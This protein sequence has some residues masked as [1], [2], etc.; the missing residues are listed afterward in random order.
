MSIK[1]THLSKYH[2][3]IYIKMNEKFPI[4][5]ISIQLLK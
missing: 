3:K 2:I 5:L 4:H 1:S